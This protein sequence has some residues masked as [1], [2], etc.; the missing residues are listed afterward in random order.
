M[1]AS[2]AASRASRAAAAANLRACGDLLQRHARV[3]P[4]IEL[5]H[6]VVHAGVGGGLVV[7]VDEHEPRPARV[8]GVLGIVGVRERVEE[9]NAALAPDGVMKLFRS[10][11]C[12]VHPHSQT[13]SPGANTHPPKNRT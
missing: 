1:H 2:T 7:L 6:E 12:A 9:I 11:S 4:A 13:S 8:A 10:Q 3:N 5:P